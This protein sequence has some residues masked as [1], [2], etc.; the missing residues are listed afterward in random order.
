MKLH[1]ALMILL[2]VP[3]ALVSAA[4]ADPSPDTEA[5]LECHRTIH[6]GIVADWERSRHSRTRPVDAL[7]KPEIERRISAA[8][9]PE[10]L[11]DVTVGCAECHTL[12]PEAHSDTFEHSGYDVHVVVSPA[13]CATCHPEERAQYA[14]NLMSRAY[15]NLMQNPVYRNLADTINGVQ[16]YHAEENATKL[17]D[18]D[19]ATNAVSCLFCHGT[20]V[21]VR[22]FITRETDFGEMTL[23][24][25]EGWPSQGVG[26]INPD[27]T[28]GACTSCHTRHRFSIEMARK[29]H[30]CSQCHKGPDVPAYKV[31]DVSKHGNL[32]S[33]MKTDWDFNAVPWTLGRDLSAPT[34]AACHVSLTVDLDGIVIAKRTHR[35]N[36]RLA[37]RIFGVYAHLHPKSPDTTVLRNR[38][39]LPLPVD[40]DGRP[41]SEG[42]IGAEEQ[43]ARRNAMQGVCRSCHGD[44]WVHTQFDRLDRTVET[45]NEMT[46]AATEVMA[47]A[48]KQGLA[49]GLEHQ[50]SLFN[51]AIEMKWVEQW[52][53]YANSTRYAA[54]MMGGDYGVFE[55][56][57]WDMSLNLQEMID[58]LEVAER[59]REERPSE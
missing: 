27:G 49:K 6:P 3:M 19:E 10:S 33:A 58:W 43:E 20:R 21:K 34:C 30:T 54:A 47:S 59:L 52:L 36:D 11:R 5:C 57:R 46:R 22:E 50:D 24:E 17:E 39:G 9:P 26:R 1:V 28:L 25:L 4:M 51:E 29:P 44:N 38:A 40:L 53:F 56:G 18:P 8:S 14:D 41:A 32:Y 35:M 55:R 37:W 7:E 12:R 16:V 23:P 48:W 31:Y 45:T 2:A 15:G 13:D 42:L